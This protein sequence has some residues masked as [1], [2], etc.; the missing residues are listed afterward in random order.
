M[1]RKNRFAISI[2]L[3]VPVLVG[4]L[5]FQR[6]ADT[7]QKS[8]QQS[9]AVQPVPVEVATVELGPIEHQ[10]L[11]SGTLQA[12]TEIVLSP[13]IGGR[14]EQL[15]VEEADIVTRG[16][17]VV[18]LDDDEHVQTVR[19]MEA[20]LAVAKANL[21]EAESLLK[22]AERELERIDNLRKRGV[23]SESQLDAA[24][25]DQL[26]KQAHVSVTRAQLV[27]AEAV[28]ESTRIRLGYTKV[29]AGWRGVGEQRVVAERFVDEGE[30]VSAN[31]PLLRI[32]ELNPISVA[33]F[34][35]ERD[36]ALLQQG[37]HAQL[38]S[39]AYPGE[40]FSGQIVRISP[41]FREST[42]QAKV[43]LEVDNPELLLKPG[44]FVRILV[45][46]ERA[47]SATIV[48]EQSLATRNGQSG[49]FVVTAQGDRVT[50]RPVTI[51]I[52]QG[53]RVQVI[54]DGIGERVVVLGQQLL[55]DGSAISI[56]GQAAVTG[57]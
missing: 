47:I 42:R 14:I 1:Q 33:F 53:G 38:T 26:A 56:A 39:D 54:G 4:W 37:Q 24:M 17:V 51:G 16:Q 36:Y 18:R 55:D 49:L 31:T 3:L 20:E 11:F 7:E 15:Y 12:L 50:W 6:L 32:V 19:Q 5:V 23:S 57:Q 29:A 27:R 46:L 45:T 43:E 2:F 41:V 40:R 44:M 21:G 30:T 48:P 35:A 9:K 52:R 34:V 22:I 28:L 10:R 25:A 8:T 13:K